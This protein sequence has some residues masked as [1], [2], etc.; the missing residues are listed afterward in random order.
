MLYESEE[1][2]IS[3]ATAGDAMVSHPLSIYREER[4][5]RLAEVL[6]GADASVCNLEM[7]IHSL[8]LPHLL[9]EGSY[10]ASHPDT[11]RELKWMGFNMVAT[12]SNH[13]F[14]FGPACSNRRRSSMRQALS[15]PAPGAILP[16]PAQP[17]T[18]IRRVVALR[19]WLR[20][21][22]FRSGRAPANSATTFM[23]VPA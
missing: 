17:A 7:P 1:G 16:K 3:I 15:T 14:D 5:L 12:A 18:W 13:V 9:A 19:C 22:R 8:D 21:P 11:A 10:A 2:N 20:P 23:A 6:R 4:F